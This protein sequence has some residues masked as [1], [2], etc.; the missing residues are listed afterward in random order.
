MNAISLCR[1]GD[2]SGRHGML[3]IA[4][5]KSD[6]GKISRRFFTDPLLP[7]A[8]THSILGRSFVLYDDRGPVARGERI[9]CSK[10]VHRNVCEANI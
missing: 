9:A 4:G 7:L 5:R 1:V 3:E 8:G 10:Y 2:L 6:A